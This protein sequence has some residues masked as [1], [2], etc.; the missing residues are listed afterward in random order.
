MK[1]NGLVTAVRGAQSYR[2]MIES[3]QQSRDG[4]PTRIQWALLDAARPPVLAA[5]QQDWK[6]TI[7][8]IAAQPERARFLQEQVTLWAPGSALSYFPAPDALFYD[9]TP[10]DGDTIRGRVRV[11]SAL[12]DSGQ[13]AVP[14]MIFTSS[15]ALM[16]LTAPP[17]MLRP[18]VT[19]L[20]TGQSVRLQGLL[21][22]LV[23]CA[24]QPV[25]VVE[26]PGTFGRRGG[27]LDIYPTN[28][29][30]PVRIELLGDQIESMRCFDPVS[31][32]SLHAIETVTLLPASEAVWPSCRA[33]PRAPK[34]CA[35]WLWH[36]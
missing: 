30:Q 25:S 23:A 11:L 10:W 28:V 5:L 24:Y 2:G 22:H 31:Q 26:E 18:G 12:A 36:A 17:R 20:S 27:I 16:T 8:V 35:G 33:L 4:T 34:R 1:L 15:W 32:R 19:R 21:N 13:S 3:L 6:G 7:L 9:L 14:S 29:D